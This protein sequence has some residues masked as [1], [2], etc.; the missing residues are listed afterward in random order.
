MI[1]QTKIDEILSRADIVD[2]IGAFVKL[3]KKGVNHQACCPFHDEKTPSFSVSQ[4]KQ[5]FKCFG[6]GEGGDVIAFLMKHENLTYPE[7]LKWLADRYKIEVNEITLTPEEQTK[8]EAV[9][10]R[11]AS[12]MTALRIIHSFYLETI[13]KNSKALEYLEKERDFSADII[14]AFGIGLAAPNDLLLQFIAENGIKRDFLIEI[15]VLKESKNGVYDPFFN[16]IIFPVWDRYGGVIGFTGRV[17]PEL[18]HHTMPKYKNSEESEVYHKS[19]TL[20]AYHLATNEIRKTK[21]AYIVEGNTDCMR[22]H[23]IGRRNTVAQMG[24]AL[25]DDQMAILKKAGAETIVLCYDSDTAGEKATVKNG[26]K[27]IKSGFA[28]EILILG[29]WGETE[30]VDADTLFKSTDINEYEPDN[31]VDYIDWRFSREYSKATTPTIK[32][33]I[34]KD[35]AVLLSAIDDETAAFYLTALKQKHNL[36]RLLSDAYKRAKKQLTAEEKETEK[37]EE[38]EDEMIKRY[39]FTIEHNKYWFQRIG[40]YGSNFILQ[41]LFH[42][43]SVSKPKRIFSI[44]NEYGIAHEIELDQKDLVSLA[45]FKLKVEGLGNFIWKTDDIS[46]T[47]LKSYLY[48]NMDTCK[49]IDQLGWQSQGFWAWSNGLF[50]NNVFYPIDEMG[51]VKLPDDMG[52][53]YLPALSKFYKRDKDIFESERRFIFRPEGKTSLYDF[54]KIMT[55]VFGDNAIVLILFYINT[56]FRDVIVK[57]TNNFPLLNLFGLKG[58]G[59]SE[60]YHRMLQAFGQH[61]MAPN[62]NSSSKASLGDHVAQYSNALCAIDEYKNSLEFEKIEFLKGLYNSTG[63]TRINMDKDKK[64]ETTKADVGIVIAGQ[65]MPTADIALFSRLLYTVFTKTEHTADEKT[66]FD[67]LKDISENGFTNITHEILSLRE[68]FKT[69]YDDAYETATQLLTDE[70]D[71][72]QIVEDRVLKNW[73]MILAGYIAI[74]DKISVYFTKDKIVKLFAKCIETQNAQTQS[75]NEISLFW[76]VVEYLFKENLIEN[77]I[78]FRINPRTEL[79]TNKSNEPF[80]WSTPKNILLMDTGRIF[81]L[82]RK[83]SKQ[84]IEQPL[85]LQSLEFYVKNS[86]EYLGIVDSVRFKVK[87][88]DTGKTENYEKAD[89]TFASTSAKTFKWKVTRALAFD[90]DKLQQNGINIHITESGDGDF[91]TPDE[92]NEKF[93]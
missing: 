69:S 52:S 87:N 76:N 48:D 44:I 79:K 56:L 40:T 70:V 85:P 82:Y 25:T 53:Y 17:L 47:Q 80:E 54:S 23:S 77:D 55:E 22:M 19:K 42:V 33:G 46:L 61:P 7:A 3:D 60:L 1:P 49:E 66:K 59:K 93:F 39:G 13:N 18:S 43:E 91:D 30:K 72:I 63:R 2:V 41:P 35:F 8:Q 73:L 5:I 31:K 38:R 9:A 81:A 15:G 21:T 62:I 51:V 4:S 10:K 37:S 74:A 12:I 65:E 11:K 88:P 64:K 32:S 14:N 68:H 71:N 58:T 78:D 50:Y 86:K 29:D 27:L 28:V 89:D 34:L 90:Y 6:C 16:R 92:N 36:Q 75:G 20:Y 83:H 26:E 45:A 24:T 67:K 84:I 57:K